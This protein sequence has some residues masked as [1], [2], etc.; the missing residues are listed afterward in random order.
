[1]KK[2]GEVRKKK[3][4]ERRKM[5]RREESLNTAIDPAIYKQL[6]RFTCR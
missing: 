1:L 4:S 5:E 3:K 6:F 2:E